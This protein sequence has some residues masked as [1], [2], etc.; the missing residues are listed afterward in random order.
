[1]DF[2]VRKGSVL[3]FSSLGFTVLGHVYTFVL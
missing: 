1:M 3:L 2:G